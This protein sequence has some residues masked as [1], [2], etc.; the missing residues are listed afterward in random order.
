[1]PRIKKQEAKTP[2]SIPL[3]EIK[4]PYYP[5]PV[6]EQETVIQI[7]RDSVEAHIYTNDLT[8]LTR[9]K[10][11]ANAEGSPWRLTEIQHMGGR[12][13]GWGFECPKKFISYRGRPYGRANDEEEDGVPE[14]IADCDA[15]PDGEEAI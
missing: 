11:A 10:R 6:S 3:T 5:C 1:M 4:P 2:I 15:F 13:C 7:S 14:A 8:M 9:F 12:Q